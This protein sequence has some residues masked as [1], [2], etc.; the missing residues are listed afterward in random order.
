[1]SARFTRGLA[2]A[3]LL[4]LGCG[5]SA[6]FTADDAGTDTGTD[7]DT[8]VD[9]DTDTDTDTDAPDAGV[10]FSDGVTLW[11]APES[12]PSTTDAIATWPD[13]SGNGHDAVQGDSAHQPHLA[14]NAVNGLA[15]PFFDGTSS[16]LTVPY[17]PLFSNESSGAT[18]VVVFVSSDPASD[19]RFV[20]VQE[21]TLCVNNF[22]IGYHTGDQ[23]RPNFGLHAGCGMADVTSANIDN[24]WHVYT[25]RVLPEGT[26]PA[27]VEIFIDGVK[28]A[29]EMDSGGF[30]GPGSYGTDANDV[31]IG[32]RDDNGSMVLD[33]F[34][35]GYL[36]ELMVFDKALD[37]TQRSAV[38]V[39]LKA[40]FGTP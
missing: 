20:F 29:T 35:N 38:E 19:Q 5:K 4:A 27:N 6:G 23:D 11:L 22:E 32:A 21:Q 33:G 26:P 24:Q 17:F 3:G 12:I 39:H 2:L 30:P 13:S 16:Y 28:Q 25:V 34:L 18:I 40:K 9:S 31:Q 10:S 1:M 15:V 37:D 7:T 8:D 36:G 14:S